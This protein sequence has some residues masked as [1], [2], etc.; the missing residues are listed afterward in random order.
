MF[1]SNFLLL[2]SINVNGESVKIK[3]NRCELLGSALPSPR[4]KYHLAR[5][6]EHV[7]T[8]VTSGKV[9]SKKFNAN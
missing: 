2:I 6:N 4:D 9:F 7:K 1:K 3:I 5:K 8:N